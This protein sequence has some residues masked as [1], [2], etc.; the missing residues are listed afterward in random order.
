MTLSTGFV[1]TGILNQT[2]Q[3]CGAYE[4]AYS[5]LLQTADPSWLYSIRQGATTIWEHWDSYTREKGFGNVGMNSFNHYAYGA[6]AE[7]LMGGVAGILPDPDAPGFRHILLYPT[8]DTRTENSVPIEQESITHAEAT[9]DSICGK[10]ASSWVLENNTF[11][12]HFEIPEGTDAEIGLLLAAHPEYY[13][14]LIINGVP[15]TEA[16]LCTAEKNGRI[17]FTLPAGSYTVRSDGKPIFQI[18]R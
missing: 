14:T 17:C 6:V 2:L 4:Y 7:W 16:E 18:N 11:T 15:R 3:E 5:L 13:G 12:Y 8:P 10:I 9:S 1:G